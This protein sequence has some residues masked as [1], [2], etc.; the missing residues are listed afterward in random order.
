MKYLFFSFNFNYHQGKLS[1]NLGTLQ[2]MNG[3]YGAEVKVPHFPGK[4][5]FQIS[6]TSRSKLRELM[7]GTSR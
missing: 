2:F 6:K 1:I 5:S 4:M 7:F 3:C